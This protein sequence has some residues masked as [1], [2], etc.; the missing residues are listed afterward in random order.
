LVLE[1]G[2]NVGSRS[3]DYYPNGVYKRGTASVRKEYFYRRV[4]F[5]GWVNNGASGASPYYDFL[6]SDKFE[7]Y[8]NYYGGSI[9]TGT[10]PVDP[11]SFDPPELVGG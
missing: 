6:V 3:V 8:A 11:Q 4:G 10:C 5:N 7:N 2:G 9:C 1:T